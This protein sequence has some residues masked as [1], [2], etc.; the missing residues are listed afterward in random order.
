MFPLPQKSYSPAKE[1]EMRNPTV[2][3]ECSFCGTPF[4]AL[5]GNV[6][7]RRTQSCGCWRHKRAVEIGRNSS[8]HGHSGSQTYKSWERMWSRVRNPKNDSYRHYGG[9]GIIVCGRWKRFENFL[10]GMGEKPKNKTLDR[11]NNNGNYEPINCR[12]ATASQQ[13][14][15]KRPFKH[16]RLTRRY[17]CKNQV[18]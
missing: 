13:Q 5:Y 8:T 2:D 9:R 10:A 1:K 3:L 16:S 18:C 12:W 6:I 4:R 17:L 11:I 14:Q 7:S 15:N